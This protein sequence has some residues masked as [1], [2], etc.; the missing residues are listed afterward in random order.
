MKL[1]TLLESVYDL[2]TVSQRVF[3]ELVLLRRFPDLYD[4]ISMLNYAT[5]VEEDG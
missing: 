5:A 1:T 4:S 2:D 3:D